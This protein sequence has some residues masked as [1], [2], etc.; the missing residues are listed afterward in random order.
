MNE[1]QS[2][3]LQATA[4][5]SFPKSTKIVGT[6]VLIDTGDVSRGEGGRLLT[7]R[8]VV[9]GDHKPDGP[10]VD[11]VM[12][13]FPGMPPLPA[14][15]LDAPT[16]QGVSEAKTADTVRGAGLEDVT[17]LS[18]RA[19]AVDG[20]ILQLQLSG[21]PQAAAVSAADTDCPDTERHREVPQ[22]RKAQRT[23]RRC[24]PAAAACP[25]RRAGVRTPGRIQ[26]SHGRS[27]HGTRRVG[28]CMPPQASGRLA[29]NRSPSR[30]NASGSE[31]SG[32]RQRRQRANRSAA[33][34]GRI[35]TAPDGNDDCRGADRVVEHFLVGDAEGG[36]GGDRLPGAEIARVSRMRAAADL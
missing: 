4:A 24:P 19:G 12:V 2:R 5:I 23:L 35:A 26:V 32:A 31:C 21:H 14:T 16:R 33:A 9:T 28:A 25:P 30:S 3:V 18:D 27:G 10:L 15:P 6:A 20:V 36:R 8:H 22:F 1:W 11:R 17:G 13:T 34:C 29:E 7:C